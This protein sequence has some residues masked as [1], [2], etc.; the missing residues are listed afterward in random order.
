MVLEAALVAWAEGHLRQLLTV[1]GSAK[2]WITSEV[3]DCDTLRRDLLASRGYVAEP[4]P[5]SL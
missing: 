4:D 2:E 1:N 3:M 5:D